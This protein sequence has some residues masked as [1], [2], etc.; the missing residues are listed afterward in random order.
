VIFDNTTPAAMQ[1]RVALPG[2]R[3]SH[4]LVV[5]PILWN[6]SPIDFCD[7]SPIDFCEV[8]CD[9]SPIDFCDVVLGQPYMWKRHVFYDSRPCSFIIT[10]GGQLY[11]IPEVFLTTTPPKKHRKAISHTAKF[12]LFTICSK[13]LQ[14]TTTTN[15]ASTPYIHQ[16]QIVEETKHI[17]SLAKMLSTQFLI[18][19]RDNRLVE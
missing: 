7:V 4:Q 11:R 1:H 15:V 17:V 6:L 2:M 3:S 16:K 12:I 8:V 10:L 13:D 14:K 9:I 19:T 5:S 18:Q